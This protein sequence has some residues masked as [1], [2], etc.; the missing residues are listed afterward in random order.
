MT[1]LAQTSSFAITLIEDIATQQYVVRAVDVNAK[2]FNHRVSFKQNERIEDVFNSVLVETITTLLSRINQENIVFSNPD[3]IIETQGLILGR[4]RML[5]TQSSEGIRNVIIRFAHFI[6]HFQNA[7]TARFG[8]D[9]ALEDQKRVAETALFLDISSPILNIISALT[10]SAL[11]DGSKVSLET[12]LKQLHLDT[13]E[14]R[15]YLEL[16]RR[17]AIQSADGPLHS[18][19]PHRQRINSA[20]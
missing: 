1:A 8:F 5:V 7:F 19:T 16:L 10:E 17:H 15:F 13:E 11:P 3:K 4:L 6:G 20:V 14:F 18:V 9:S 12:R 2:Q